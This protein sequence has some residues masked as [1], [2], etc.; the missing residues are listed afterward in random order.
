[1]SVADF[2]RDRLYP[3]T[4]VLPSEQTG[5]LFKFNRNTVVPLVYGQT[6]IKGYALP[7]GVDSGFL[8]VVYI[9]AEGEIEEYVSYLIDGQ[10]VSEFSGLYSFTEYF[11]TTTQTYDADLHTLDSNWVE[12]LTSTAYVVAKFKADEKFNSIPTL[13]AVIKG[14]KVYDHRI[15]AVAY[16]ENPILCS[17]DL[18]RSE[19]YGGSATDVMLDWD[20]VDDA[21]N[22]CG[23]SAGG[24]GFTFD[25]DLLSIDGTVSPESGYEITMRPGEGVDGTGAVA[26]EEATENLVATNPGFEDGDETGWS[27]NCNST[28]ATHS[29]VSDKSYGGSYSHKMVQDGINTSYG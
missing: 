25:A 5:S 9:F 15:D 6:P 29:V 22:D 17:V 13:E 23:D 18:K 14:R 10:A 24:V 4:G 19:R 2:W 16:S 21:A 8:Y 7:V 28:Y 1:M 3:R 27:W 26:V 11:G 12:P 20:T